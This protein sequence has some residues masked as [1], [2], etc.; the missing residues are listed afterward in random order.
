MKLLNASKKLISIVVLSISAVSCGS[1][2]E[3]QLKIEKEKLELEKKKIELEREKFDLSNKKSSD[4][5]TPVD[6]TEERQVYAS[7][8]SE[9]NQVSVIRDFYSDFDYAFDYSSMNEYINRYYSSSLRSSYSKTEL[10]SYNAYVSKEHQILDIILIS[11]TNTQREFKVTFYF[12]YEKSVGGARSN[13]CADFITL[14]N[15]NKII[16]RREIGRVN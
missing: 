9:N 6:K 8:P 15:G 1:S 13:K 16:A 7:M 5:N 4:Q 11:E 2:N 12:N 14:D 10:P 3:E